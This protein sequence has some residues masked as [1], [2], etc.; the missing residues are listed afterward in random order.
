MAALQRSTAM[1]GGKRWEGLVARA[2]FH[3]RNRHRHEALVAALRTR[4]TTH[5]ALR[6]RYD[7]LQRLHL[8][9]E[10]ESGDMRSELF[11]LRKFA[12]QAGAT[13]GASGGSS[14]AARDDEAAR[15]AAARTLA[16][17]R[18][19]NL[20]VLQRQVNIF[21]KL[22][23]WKYMLLM[24]LASSTNHVI[25]AAFF[26]IYLLVRRGERARCTRMLADA[27]CPVKG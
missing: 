27:A 17:L 15:E 26:T 3:G 13:W 25:R 8:S 7:A 5:A 14:A 21:S 24:L 6:G 23:N 2:L 16:D 10:A 19:V 12:P 18:P 9:L 4:F 11:R 22:H 20:S 1:L